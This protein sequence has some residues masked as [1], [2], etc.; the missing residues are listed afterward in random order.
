MDKK[1]RNISMAIGGAAL[2]GIVAYFAMPK[3]KREELNIW[4]N[5]KL[6]E[7]PMEMIEK[8]KK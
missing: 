4:V 5:E 3:D 8:R 2:A 7:E 6:I 1:T